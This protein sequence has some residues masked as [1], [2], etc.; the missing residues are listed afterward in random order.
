MAALI[1]FSCSSVVVYGVQWRAGRLKDIHTRH[2]IHKPLREK[3]LDVAVS[4]AEARDWA[5]PSS[6]ETFPSCCDRRAPI[7]RRSHCLLYCCFSFF[8]FLSS[9]LSSS[10]IHNANNIKTTLSCREI[11][12]AAKRAKPTTDPSLLPRPSRIAKQ[13]CQTLLVP[14]FTLSMPTAALMA[15]LGRAWQSL[16]WQSVA[17]STQTTM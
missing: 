9:F 14:G 10:F 17:A 11:F 16:A 13:L 12:S 2:R 3:Y 6:Y 15:W 1:V 7:A 5:V 8:F 4:K